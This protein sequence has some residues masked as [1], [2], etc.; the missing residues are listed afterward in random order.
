VTDEETT[1]DGVGRQ[2]VTGLW[3]GRATLTVLALVVLAG[4][5]GL[6]GVHTTTSSA[7]GDGYRLSVDYPRTARAGLDVTWRVTVDSPAGFDQDVRLAVTADYFDIYESQ[8]W[9]P[10]PDAQTRDEE[11]LYLTFAKPPSD[12]F[13]VTF[14]AYVQPSSQLGRDARIALLVDGREVAAVDIDTWLAP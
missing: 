9:F 5:V 11:M 3:S 8:G 4:A 12:R 10:E 13:V 7:S 14:D 1:L 6:L 2:S